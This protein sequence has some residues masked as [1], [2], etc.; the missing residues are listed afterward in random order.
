[1]ARP[2]VELVWHFDTL[3]AATYSPNMYKGIPFTMN[4]VGAWWAVNRPVLA[5]SAAV[6]PMMRFYL[7]GYSL[8]PVVA[9]PLL[10]LNTRNISGFLPYNPTDFHMAQLNYFDRLAIEPYQPG[11]HV[12]VSNL[13]G[14]NSFG[15]VLEHPD[16]G[17]YVFEWRS[18]TLGHTGPAYGGGTGN[19]PNV[20]LG[21]VHEIPY[22]STILG[23]AFTCVYP[24]GAGSLPNPWIDLMYG[25][26]GLEM[27]AFNV[28]LHEDANLERS[29][30]TTGFST[31]TLSRGQLVGVR[32]ASSTT[33]LTKI[34][35]MFHAALWLKRI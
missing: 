25:E 29:F 9:L 6:C 16:P 17:V 8:Y 1:M 15:L 13:Y 3:N 7:Y 30:I 2:Y 10:P 18:D 20:F 12:P 32:D 14:G 11:S 22:D 21:G 31:P 23:A 19:D 5:P 34:S 27:S 26:N 35:K 33:T 24:T 4:I 28:L